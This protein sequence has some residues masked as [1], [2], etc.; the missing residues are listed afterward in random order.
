MEDLTAA[1]Q[2]FLNSEEGAK[3]LNELTKMLGLNSEDEKTSEE[4]PF[5]PDDI[6][7]LQ[8]LMGSFNK[9]NPNTTLLKSLK[10]LLKKERQKKVD[11]AVKIMKLISLFPELKESGI[12]TNLLG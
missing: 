8:K 11:D 3:Q 2:S 4:N 7:K 12:L 9:E 1:L 6:L 10:P 5:S